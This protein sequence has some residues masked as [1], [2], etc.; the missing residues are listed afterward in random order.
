MP[1]PA[2][3]RLALLF[4]DLDGFKPV[5]DTFGHSIGDSVLEQV[6]QRLKAMSRGKRL[7]ARVGGDEFL[8][9]LSNVTT[10]DAR[11]PGRRRA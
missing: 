5:N 7:V 11:G 2:A 4:I 3:S 8:L 6:G 10:Q 9:L 1:T